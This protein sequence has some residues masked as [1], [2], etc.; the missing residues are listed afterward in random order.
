MESIKRHINDII[1]SHHQLPSFSSPCPSIDSNT[2]TPHHHPL[3]SLYSWPIVRCAGFSMAQ[4]SYVEEVETGVTEEG[5]PFQPLIKVKERVAETKG[6]ALVCLPLLLVLFLL[7]AIAV[8]W[9]YEYRPPYSVDPSLVLSDGQPY[10]SSPPCEPSPSPR[11]LKSSR[12]GYIAVM[13]SGTVRSFSVAFHSHLVNLFAP[14]P[15]TVHIF[16][17]YTT[18]RGDWKTP[19]VEHEHVEVYHSFNTTL[20]YWG[21]YTNLDGEEVSL[22]DD[23]LVWSTVNDEVPME[24]SERFNYTEAVRLIGDRY[25]INSRPMSL[26]GALDS[27]RQVNQARLDYERA[28]NVKYAWVLRMRMDHVM[29]SNIW[30]DVFDIQPVTNPA[31]PTPPLPLEL[32]PSRDP[33]NINLSAAAYGNS[34]SPQPHTSRFWNGGALYD[35]V[36]TPHP[37]LSL[38]TP[39]HDKAFFV[40]TNDW[41]YGVSDQFAMGGSSALT[42]YSERFNVP[43]LKTLLQQPQWKLW[44][45]PLVAQVAQIEG[46][47]VL[48]IRHVYNILRHIPTPNSAS[49]SSYVSSR[50]VWIWY[51]KDSMHDHCSHWLGR[52]ERMF[53]AMLQSSND[54]ATAQMAHEPYANMGVTAAAALHK[55][56]DTVNGAI[57]STSSS[58]LRDFLSPT[59]TNFYYFWR[60]RSAKQQIP[61]VQ[62]DRSVPPEWAGAADAE[63]LPG[64]PPFDLY[65]YTYYPFIAPTTDV[66]ATFKFEQHVTCEQQ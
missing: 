3:P 8:I 33:A 64:H 28:H 29:K 21:G 48:P 12:R 25:D 18:G 27:Q 43:L 35:M 46:L 54:S 51:G 41:W 13:Y 39:Y 15:Y 65:R 44:A 57:A 2:D 45:E 6:Q 63:Q 34:T 55:Y 66:L 20:S 30:E 9:H 61:C 22:M 1:N 47:T 17:H 38:S 56:V 19:S 7:W 36:Y 53:S 42:A 10:L 60:Y 31:P 50:C 24:S 16:A 14:S 52:Q 4:E 11:T 32:N 40:P 26:V 23:C 59:S 37:Y 49:V 5:D 58:V 62:P